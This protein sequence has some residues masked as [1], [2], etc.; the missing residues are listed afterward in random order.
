MYLLFTKRNESNMT[1]AK[2]DPKTL[3]HLK[4]W[5]VPRR[6]RE[7]GSAF[8]LDEILYTLRNCAE[9]ECKLQGILDLSTG[10]ALDIHLEFRNPRNFICMMAFNPADSCL[11]IADNGHHY[12]FVLAFK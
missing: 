11:Y 7:M 8:I 2:V 9:P 10:K 6:F 3:E 12:R 4:T 5:A 1:I